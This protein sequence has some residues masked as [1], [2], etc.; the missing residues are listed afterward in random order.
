MIALR[1]VILVLLMVVAGWVLG[2]TPP[3][4][5]QIVQSDCLGLEYGGWICEITLEY[6]GQT[7]HDVRIVDAPVETGVMYLIPEEEDTTHD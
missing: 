5:V 7:L 1:L 2:S 4:F 6:D 3:T